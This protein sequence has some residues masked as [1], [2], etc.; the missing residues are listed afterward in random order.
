MITVEALKEAGA[1]V[2]SGLERCLGNEA[3]YLKFVNMVLD[4]DK[5]EA[6]RAAV[7]AGDL[8]QGFEC[9]HALKGVLAN[10]SL[11]NVLRPVS[12][13]TEALRAGEDR[14]YSGLLD[15]MDNERAK[16][17]ALK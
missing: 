10:I 5:F 13:M 2:D 16:L 12:E 17:L 8:K 14:D 6:L 4:D 9:A 1:E 7:E 11:S 3:M 15:E